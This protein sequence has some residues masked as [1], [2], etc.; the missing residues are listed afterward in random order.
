V[1]ATLELVLPIVR[2]AAVTPLFNGAGAGDCS[3][4]AAPMTTATTTTPIPTG[5]TQ[6][7]KPLCFFCGAALRGD[8]QIPFELD[9]IPLSRK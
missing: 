9:L 2:P 3:R 6:D 7:G 1:K 4:A 8:I 5:I